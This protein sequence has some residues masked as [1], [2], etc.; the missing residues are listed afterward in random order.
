[1]HRTS[2]IKIAFTGPLTPA[3]GGVVHIGPYA[4][5]LDD[6]DAVF[7]RNS[8]D[9]VNF[10]K[11]PVTSAAATDQYMILVDPRADGLDGLPAD[12]EITVSFPAGAIVNLDAVA[13]VCTFRTLYEDAVPPELVSFE[14]LGVQTRYGVTRASDRRSFFTLKFSEK[15]VAAPGGP[16]VTGGRLRTPIPASDVLRRRDCFQ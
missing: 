1:M 15:V 14:N 8:A 10:D 4:Q 9:T 5:R 7:W 2:A 12:T 16:D 6:R 11:L 13:E 3:P